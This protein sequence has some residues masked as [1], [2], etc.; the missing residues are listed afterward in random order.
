VGNYG[1]DHFFHLPKIGFGLNSPRPIA[2]TEFWIA[3]FAL[4]VPNLGF[5]SALANCGAFPSRPSWRCWS[6]C[7]TINVCG[8]VRQSA[9]T[10]QRAH[11]GNRFLQTAA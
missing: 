7:E 10:A 1:G 4:C 2:A 3:P 6:T 5:A 8:L 9:E 11:S